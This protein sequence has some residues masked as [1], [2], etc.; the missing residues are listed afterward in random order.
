[1]TIDVI[2]TVLSSDKRICTALEI[3]K[4]LNLKDCW[5]GAGFIRNCIWDYLH[6]SKTEVDGGDVDVVFY[7]RENTSLEYEQQLESMLNNLNPDFPWS[8]KNQARMQLKYNLNYSTTL[9]AISFWPETATC[10]AARLNDSNVIEVIAPYG[11]DDLLNL[12][13]RPSPRIDTAVFYNRVK[14]KGWLKKWSKLK[15]AD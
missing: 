14:E 11:Y 6:N 7:D 4:K 8:V 10:I 13:L 15:V 5:I 9:E 12:I 1:M 3:V 2:T